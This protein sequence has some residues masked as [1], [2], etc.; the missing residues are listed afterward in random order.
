MMKTHRYICPM[1]SKYIIKQNKPKYKKKK[2]C[3]KVYNSNAIFVNPPRR[4]DKETYMALVG[5]K[6][7]IA[8]LCKKHN[9]L[10][11]KVDEGSSGSVYE[12]CLGKKDCKYVLKISSVQNDVQLRTAEKETYFLRLLKDKDLVPKI[13]DSWICD[14]NYY[15]IMDAYEMDVATLGSQQ[16]KQHTN[17]DQGYFFTLL[18]FQLVVEKNR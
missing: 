11:K 14:K 13:Y 10:K 5:I 9:K 7:P 2:R 4:A 3:G 12:A 16:M 17:F 8:E 15:L 18:Q 1:Y 6:K